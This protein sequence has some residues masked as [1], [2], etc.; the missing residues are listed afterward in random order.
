MNIE[1]HIKTLATKIS[2]SLGVLCKLRHILPK[3]AHR[4]LY[5]LVIYPHLLYGITVW[6]NSFDKHLKTLGTLRN[7]AVK[8]ISAAQWLDHVAPPDLKVQILKL[9]NLSKN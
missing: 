9:N 5:H 2:R 1:E 4:N 7:K 8:L 3:S 6:G